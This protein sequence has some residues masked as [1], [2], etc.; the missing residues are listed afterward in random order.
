MTAAAPLGLGRIHTSGSPDTR[1]WG[2]LR[3]PL[4]GTVE[5]GS[6]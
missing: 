1:I 6:P 5:D 3:L 2:R 4:G